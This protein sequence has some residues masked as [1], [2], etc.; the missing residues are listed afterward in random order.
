MIF[1]KVAVAE[2]V[3]FVAVKT[4][5]CLVYAL[6]CH[7]SSVLLI[8]LSNAGPFSHEAQCAVIFAIAQLSCLLRFG[9]IE[10]IIYTEWVKKVPDT[11]ILSLSLENCDKMI[12]KHSTSPQTHRYT[13]LRNIYVRK[14]ECPVRA[15][16]GSLA[17]R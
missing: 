12:I 2:I 9:R 13:I 3:R 10:V 16:Y 6:R 11:A 8:L 4:R 7:R 14:L 17:E 1:H 5:H 15:L